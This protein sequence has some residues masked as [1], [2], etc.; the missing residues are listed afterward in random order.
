VNSKT[1]D[2]AFRIRE[3]AQLVGSGD[4]LSRRTGI[5][6]RTLENYLS[7]RSE[8]KAAA[9]SAIAKTAGVSS[10]WLLLGVEPMRTRA[11]GAAIERPAAEARAIVVSTDARLLGRLS[12]QIAKIFKEI[13]RSAPL[14]QIVEFAV[15]Y[16]DRIVATVAD[17]DERLMVGGALLADLRRELNSAEKDSKKQTASDPE[18]SNT[19]KC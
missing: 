12:D 9:V 5:P 17:P 1:A 19:G 13:G 11:F 6:R 2:L 8:P 14:H 16:H 18:T 3:C 15:E 7:G 10:D 4:E